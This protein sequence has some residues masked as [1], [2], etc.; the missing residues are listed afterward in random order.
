MIYI[1]RERN[2]TGA[3]D[4]AEAIT[5]QGTHARRTKGL[6]LRT[7]QPNDKVV[8]WGSHFAAPAGV[9]TL[10]NV[11]PISKLAEA[12]RLA[13][14][15]VATIQVSAE[16]PRVVAAR[17]IYVPGHVNINGGPLNPEQAGERLRQLQQFIEQERA[18]RAAWEAQPA[19]PAEIWLPRR[20]NHV[21]GND[22]LT[23]NLPNPQYFSKKE[24]IIEEYRLHMFKGKSIRAGKKVQRATR[25]DG[26]TPAHPWIRS[27]D[28]G[29]VIQYDNF[30]STKPMRTIA[31]SA[32]EALGLDFGAVDVAKRRDNSLIVLEVNRAPGVE[33][34]T[35]DAYARHI[36]AW[37]KE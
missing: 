5:L 37:S 22:L 6:A 34:G 36:I 14:A 29:W 21:G 1:F 25:P 13:A 28:A 15:G 32:L 11:A 19:Q 31:A 10:N 3:R 9:R 33:N 30:E 35:T 24:D 4:L 18:R 8:C 23:E 7:L 2:S 16:R 20:N 17:P 12:Q 26:R 27:F